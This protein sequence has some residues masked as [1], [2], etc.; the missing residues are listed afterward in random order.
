M[1]SVPES[2]SCL[3]PPAL[4]FLLAERRWSYTFNGEQNNRLRV[5]QPLSC[6]PVGFSCWCLS[7]WQ[8][9]LCTVRLKVLIKD[10]LFF[11]YSFS[12]AHDLCSSGLVIML[13][14]RNLILG[15]AEISGTMNKISEHL[16][17]LKMIWESYTVCC[18]KVFETRSYI[19]YGNR[20]R[21]K[22]CLGNLCI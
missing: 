7:G 4:L 9:F 8:N 13:Y 6:S 14:C 12:N 15:S 16:K 2:S 22:S 18:R 20:L 3:Y 5:P 1:S 11:L 10:R 21:F 19:L 17:I